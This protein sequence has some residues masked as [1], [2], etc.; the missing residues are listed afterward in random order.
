[1]T[2]NFPTPDPTWDYAAIWAQVFRAQAEV[3]Q[4]RQLLAD[5]EYAS[6][7]VDVQLRQHFHNLQAICIRVSGMLPEELPN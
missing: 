3:E 7:E 5:T 4:L 6:A 1:M 2:A